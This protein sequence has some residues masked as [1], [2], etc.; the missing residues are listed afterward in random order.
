MSLSIAFNPTY[1]T[2]GHA[3]FL[4]VV[5]YF[6]VLF[7]GKRQRCSVNREQLRSD[8]QASTPLGNRPLVGNV[9][10]LL[11]G[12]SGHLSLSVLGQF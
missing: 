5:S 10:T 8:I 12:Q 7:R 9:E 11:V 6:R 1:P 4:Y 2:T 3:A